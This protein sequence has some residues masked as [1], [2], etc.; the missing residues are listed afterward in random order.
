MFISKFSPEIAR[1]VCVTS[2]KQYR[3]DKKIMLLPSWK[4]NATPLISHCSFD[5]RMGMGARDQ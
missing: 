4:L 3:G 1:G 2:R 5:S